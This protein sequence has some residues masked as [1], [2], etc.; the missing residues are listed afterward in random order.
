MPHMSAKRRTKPTKPT[1]KSSGFS[2]PRNEGEITEEQHDQAMRVLRQEYYKSVRGIVQELRERLKAGDISDWDQAVNEAVD[3]SY[4]VI[5]TH[6]NMQ[7]LMCSDHHDAYTEDFGQAPVEGDSINWGALAFGALYRDVREQ[8]DAEGVEPE[9]DEAP[10]G[11][12]R[13]PKPR[14]RYRRE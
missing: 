1:K 2:N 14:A 12:V 9:V 10:R 8:L 4:W 7:V 11:R 3:G 13:S 5:Y 6:A